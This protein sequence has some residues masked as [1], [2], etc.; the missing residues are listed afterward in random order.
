MFRGPS[1]CRCVKSNSHCHARHDKT[2]LSVSRTLRR[3]ELDSRQ[4]QT[5]ADRKVSSLNT[6]RAI[7]QFTP[8]HQTRHR[9]GRVLPYLAG[10][11]NW[12]LDTLASRAKRLNRLTATT[13]SAG[14]QTCTGHMMAMPCGWRVKAEL[15]YSGRGW[16]GLVGVKPYITAPTKIFFHHVMLLALLCIKEL[17]F[18]KRLSL[19]HKSI[20]PRIIILPKSV[21]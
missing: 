5:V 6:L 12:A 18:K 11:V 8:S 15:T 2:V 20:K 13:R 19:S 16:W 4:L 21:I 17:A 14:R 7:V 3:C 10:D 9:Q 1:V